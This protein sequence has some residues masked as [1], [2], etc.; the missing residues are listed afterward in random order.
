MKNNLKHNSCLVFQR[1]PLRVD[2]SCLGIVMGGGYI[3][4][5][6]LTGT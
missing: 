2:A 4:D 6:E 3:L 1:N 5:K